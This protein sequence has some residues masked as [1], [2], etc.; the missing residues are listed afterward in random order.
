M[1]Q[2][3]DANHDLEKVATVVQYQPDWCDST[4]SVDSKFST[5]ANHLPKVFE[6]VSEYN[7]LDC[8]HAA[9]FP[10]YLSNYGLPAASLTADAAKK[11]EGQPGSAIEGC[12]T[13][14]AACTD[15]QIKEWVERQRQVGGRQRWVQQG[16]KDTFDG[17]DDTFAITPDLDETKDEVVVLAATER[18]RGGS[19]ESWWHIG[20]NAAKA[21]AGAAL[22]L[23][24]LAVLGVSTRLGAG[25]YRHIRGGDASDS[26]DWKD[27]EEEEGDDDE[28][29]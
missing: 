23:V 6:K 5:I 2:L 13:P 11:L 19:K 28:L 16:G 4:A 15:G 17:F 12:E 27:L 26:D 21:L 10:L 29:S 8:R 25:L 24:A 18:P 3:G 14:S 22:L 1:S 20:G 7:D 9:I